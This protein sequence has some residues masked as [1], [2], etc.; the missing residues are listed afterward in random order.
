MWTML[1]AFA[2][3]IP[4]RV[5]EYVKENWG[6]P[7]IAGFMVLLTASAFALS[8]GFDVL[9]NEVAIYS[10]CALVAGV[11]FQFIC[12]LKCNKRKGEKNSDSV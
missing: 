2:R 12:Y 6:A 7:F 1:R 4:S 9:A 5:K 3:R 10:Y 8:L 11:I